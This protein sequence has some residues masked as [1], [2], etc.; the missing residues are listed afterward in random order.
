MVAGGNTFA[1]VPKAHMQ[2]Y[3][4]SGSRHDAPINMHFPQIYRFEYDRQVC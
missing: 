3:I 2:L 1:K 4:P